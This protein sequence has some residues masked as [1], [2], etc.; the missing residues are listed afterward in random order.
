M[1]DNDEYAFWRNALAGNFGEMHDSDPQPGF[2]RTK[3]RDGIPLPVAIWRDGGKMIAVRNEEPVEADEVWTWC[4]RYPISH[5]T[6]KTVINGGEW[7]DM[8][9][10]IRA[11]LK[12]PGRGHNEPPDERAMLL[13]QIESALA[14]VDRYAEITDPEEMGGAQSLR[15]RLNELSGLADKHREKE[16]RPHLDAAKETDAKWMPLVKRPKEGADTLKA[17][18]QLFVNKNAAQ[19][20]AHRD[21]AATGDYQPP[22][23]SPSP[24]IP[25]KI[26]GGYGRAASTRMRNKAKVT[27]QDQ[28]YQYFRDD[29]AV[30]E[31]L[32]QLAQR[33]TDRG[34]TVPGTQVTQEIVIT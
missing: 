19:Q 29:P 3:G 10:A 9:G 26:K 14:G 1:S 30:Q 22:A 18:M 4:C 13:D 7:P 28:V 6:Y 12:V 33:G 8:D 16:K 32:A 25:D 2:Y 17:S 5:Q 23:G 27:D 11:S 20:A 21:R 24:L 31:L 15:A 34:L